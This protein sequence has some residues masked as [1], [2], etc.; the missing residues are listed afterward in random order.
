[1]DKNTTI[2]E[3]IREAKALGKL[4]VL[5]KIDRL[6]DEGSDTDDIKIY[7]EEQV[8]QLSE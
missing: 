2:N 7:I 5:V 6:I 4:E 1:M 3:I 8:S